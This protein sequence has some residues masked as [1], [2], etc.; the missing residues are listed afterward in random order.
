MYGIIHFSDK[1]KYGKNKRNLPLYRF[2]PYFKQVNGPSEKILIGSKKSHEMIDYYGIIDS[3]T[4][5]L[6]ELIG[7]V[8]DYSSIKKFILKINNIKINKE[9]IEYD[10]IDL[11]PEL[12]S[13]FIFT[14]D[15]ET[16]LDYDDAF[17]YDF[18][19]KQ[20]Y[21]FITD[22]TNIN[23]KNINNLINIYS[24]FYD[25][26][27]TYNLF[28][29]NISHNSHSLIKGHRRNVISMIINLNNGNVQ[30]KK[31]SITV[32]NN[33]TYSNADKLLIEDEMWICFKSDIE[34]FFGNKIIDSHDLIEKL[35]IYYNSTFYLNISNNIFPIRTH[36]GLKCDSDDIK[37]IQNINSD[38]LKK[39]CY[40]SAEYVPSNSDYALHYGLNI[41]MYMHTTSPLRRVID[42]ISQKI[43]FS[44]CTYNI[45]E[46]CEICNQRNK[47]FKNAYNQIKLLDLLYEIK[48]SENRKFN[49][50]ITKFS[51]SYLSIFIPEL[52]IFHKIFF[53]NNKLKD[54]INITI[55]DDKVFTIKH[56][57]HEH[58]LELNLYQQ[59]EIEAM[60]TIS[61]S[62][63]CNKVKFYI[64]NPDIS[65][66][67]N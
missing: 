31:Q 60:I 37:I 62:K 41:N 13:D 65:F 14:I 45:E 15:N 18:A 4:Y 46:I 64:V 42:H 56:I 58:T 66:I 6:N 48:D 2:I 61:E 36:K 8:N 67:L 5:S 59:I 35:M 38:L 23:I 1:V 30:F 40:H 52:D 20:L 54:L 24:S 53:F 10:K 49:A 7:P 47:E 50:I 11:S 22:T 12:N 43:A 57:R 16:T 3:K 21:I 44:N 63:L 51:E 29:E 25:Y 32:K 19:N 17:S 39:L 28:P 33:L 55:T 34:Q 27:K 9:D 26:D